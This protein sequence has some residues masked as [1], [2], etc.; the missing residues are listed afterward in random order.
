[1]NFLRPLTFLPPFPAFLF[2]ASYIMNCTAG[3]ITRM[4][5][6]SVPF[7]RALTPSLLMICEKAS[8][9]DSTKGIQ[10]QEGVYIHHQS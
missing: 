9:G 7:H 3:L 1:M 8:E 4:R 2:M 6:G 10:I 5:E